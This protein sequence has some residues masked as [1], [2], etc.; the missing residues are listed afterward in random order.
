MSAPAEIS[1]ASTDP[2][3]R[4]GEAAPVRLRCLAGGAMP[5]DLRRDAQR[6]DKLSDRLLSALP[7][8]LFACVV[9]PMSPELGQELSRLCVR[10]EVAEA[11][12]GHVI[13]VVRWLVPPA[14]SL[15]RDRPWSGG[16]GC[17]REAGAGYGAEPHRNRLVSPARSA[18]RSSARNPGRISGGRN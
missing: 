7:A 15:A 9:Q 11:D 12:L 5:E 6:F 18:L 8:V 10:A 2:K 14:T 1:L 17:G 3:E 4:A 16:T 13:R